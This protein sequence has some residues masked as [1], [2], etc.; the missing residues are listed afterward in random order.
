MGWMDLLQK[1][2]HQQVNVAESQRV[3]EPG[4]RTPFYMLHSKTKCWFVDCVFKAAFPNSFHFPFD[5]IIKSHSYIGVV[6]CSWLVSGWIKELISIVR[7]FIWKMGNKEVKLDSNL[8]H[9]KINNHSKPGVNPSATRWNRY[10]WLK[11]FYHPTLVIWK[12]DHQ[13]THYERITLWQ[14]ER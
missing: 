13:L 9:Y 8:K 2:S 10:Q 11:H 3:R 1:L 6:V 12:T 4:C 5:P 7:L 14:H